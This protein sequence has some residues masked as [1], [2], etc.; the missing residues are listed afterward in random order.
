MS[1]YGW[2]TNPLVEYYIQEYASDGKGSGQGNMV[3][4][5]TSDGS[6]YN[7]YSHQQVNQPS[8]QGTR[9]FQQY[10]SVRQ[11]PRPNG[12]EVTVQNHFNAWASKGLKLGTLSYQVFATEGWG[13]AS[14]SSH[15]TVKG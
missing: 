7:I 4:T 1:V 5:L 9:T 10:I 14:G 2:S 3:G 15:Y 8:I 13:G 12:G 6:T 11:N